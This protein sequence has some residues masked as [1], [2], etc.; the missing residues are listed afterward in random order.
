VLFIQKI[1][2]HDFVYYENFL[3]YV[4]QMAYSW[5]SEKFN[6]YSC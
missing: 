1:P 4:K 6:D 5:R 2:F 3:G